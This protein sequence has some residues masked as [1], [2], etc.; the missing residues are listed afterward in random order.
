MTKEAQQKN[1]TPL[2]E[3][4]SI[5]LYASFEERFDALC[6]GLKVHSFTHYAR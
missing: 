4:K 1:G 5:N 2:S 6:K 3:R